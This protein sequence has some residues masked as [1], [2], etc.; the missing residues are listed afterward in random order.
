MLYV[1][2]PDTNSQD[3]YRGGHQGTEKGDRIAHSYNQSADSRLGQRPNTVQLWKLLPPSL[4][5]QLEHSGCERT[6]LAPPFCPGLRG[7]TWRGS[8][9]ASDCLPAALASRDANPRAARGLAGTAAPGSGGF[10]CAGWAAP[11]GVDLG[12]RPA[13]APGMPRCWPL[14]AALGLGLGG[15]R[16]AGTLRSGAPVEVGEHADREAGGLPEGCPDPALFRWAADAGQR[17]SWRPNLSARLEQRQPFQVAAGRAKEEK[18]DHEIL[19]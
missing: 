7:R 6:A 19:S 2:D 14:R 16:G 11:P 9:V 8:R 4:D 3:P 5:G 13:R 17:T 1:I 12:R 18:E 10:G 15:P